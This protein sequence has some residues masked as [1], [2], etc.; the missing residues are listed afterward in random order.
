[1]LIIPAKRIAASASLQRAN[2]THFGGSMR[3]RLLRWSPGV[4]VAVAMEAAAERRVEW[5]RFSHPA[6]LLADHW[7]LDS[8]LCAHA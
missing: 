5:R 2:V 8:G 6:R 3:V 1:M 7:L 4:V